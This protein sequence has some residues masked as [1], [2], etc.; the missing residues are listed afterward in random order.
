MFNFLLIFLFMPIYIFSYTP[1][2]WSHLDSY[3]FKG[4]LGGPNREVVKDADGKV[5]YSAI[6]HYNPNGFIISEEYFNDKKNSDGKTIFE[7]DKGK[8]VKEA[9][10]DAD[11]T[12]K[13][14]KVFKYNGN[15][16]EKINLYNAKQDLVLVCTIN[17]FKHNMVTIAETKWTE[18]EDTEK[19]TIAQAEKDNLIFIQNIYNNLNVKVGEIKLFFN[20]NGQLI[21]RENIQQ[22]RHRLNQMK[23]DSSGNLISYTF[24]V[25]QGDKWV[26]IKTHILEYGEGSKTLI[27]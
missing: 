16:L 10:Y 25:K 7:Y 20:S 2:K 23:Y 9:L 14:R 21:K 11:N 8:I 12:L 27:N 24:H 22:E 5:I 1:G 26:L 6:Y 19:F 13:E 15:K 4:K 3:I 17:E 18:S